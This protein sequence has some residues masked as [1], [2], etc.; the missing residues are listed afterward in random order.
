[1]ETIGKQPG[2]SPAR[3]L[4]KISCADIINVLRTSGGFVPETAPDPVRQVVR[5][6]LEKI[7]R[8]EQTVAAE[9]TLLSLVSA[10]LQ[11]AQAGDTSTAQQA[12]KC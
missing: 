10:A 12:Q 4:D 2:F 7:Q 3:P 8:A 11:Q 5:G 9:T 6:G 1:V